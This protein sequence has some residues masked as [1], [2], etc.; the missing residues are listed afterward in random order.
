MSVGWNGYPEGSLPGPGDE[1]LSQS[2]KK[3]RRFFNLLHGWVYR[4]E[5]SLRHRKVLWLIDSSFRGVG[6]ILFCS[7]PVSGLFF[8]GALASGWWIIAPY[9]LAGS[10][11]STLTAYF[12]RQKAIL[13]GM[14]VFGYNGALIGLTWPW[15]WP[16]NIF[17]PFLFL[18]ASALSALLCI[19]LMSSMNNS[20]VNLPILSIPFVVIFLIFLMVGYAV[21]LQPQRSMTPVQVNLKSLNLADVSQRFS[22]PEE[23]PILGRHFL[24]QIIPLSLFLIGIVIHSRISALCAFLGG[25]ISFLVAFLLMGAD[26]FFQRELHGFTSVPIAVALGGFFIAF[27]LPCLFYTVFATCLGIFLWLLIAPFLASHEIPTLTIIFNIVTLLFLLP[28]RQPRLALKIP[29]L[30]AV[31]LSRAARPEETR[32]WYKL[33]R[34]AAR[35]WKDLK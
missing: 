25:V 9:C 2:M 13:V 16:I 19:P 27:N 20:R 31:N 35:Y 5:R 8:L 6:Q 32:R 12:M 15:F 24:H 3:L 33:H 11:V 17:S 29:W 14:G 34:T 10:A 1:P 23:W 26:A 22:S 4:E 30:F 7:H 28:L 21:G 18:F